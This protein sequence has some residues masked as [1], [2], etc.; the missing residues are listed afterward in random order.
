M[1]EKLGLKKIRSQIERGMR[2]RAEAFVVKKKEK[3]LES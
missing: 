1:G 2:E 3:K